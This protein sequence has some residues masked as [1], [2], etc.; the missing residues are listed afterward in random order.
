MIESVIGFLVRRHGLHSAG[1]GGADAR[2]GRGRAFRGG[3]ALPATGQLHLRPERAAGGVP[4]RWSVDVIGLALDGEEAAVQALPLRD[5]RMIDRYGFH[6]ENVAGEDENGARGVRD[7]VL[8]RPKHRCRRRCPPG[9]EDTN[10]IAQF[11][12]ERRG[13]PV[14]VRVPLRG[15]EASPRRSAVGERAGRARRGHGLLRGTR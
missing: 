5:G 14:D 9:I 2:G 10:A 4:V 6:L 1:A 11:L 15:E 8:R 7:R 12:S 13:A 3:G